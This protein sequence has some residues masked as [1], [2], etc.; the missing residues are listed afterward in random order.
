MI[1][2]HDV[3]RRALVVISCLQVTWPIVT[4]TAIEPL[5]HRFVALPVLQSIDSP[6]I[7]ARLI[8][9]RMA[10]AC[11]SAGYAP[12]YPTWP[13]RD[14]AVRSAVGMRPRMVLMRCQEH[15]RACLAKDR[16]IECLSLESAAIQAPEPADDARR[17]TVESLF[18][19]ERAAADPAAFGRDETAAA[20]QLLH[21]CEL[22]LGH[23]DCPMRST[24]RSSPTPIAETPSLH[25][26]LSFV[27]HDEG[28]RQQRWCFRWLA[29]GQRD[30]VP[31]AAKGGDDGL[32][33]RPGAQVPPSFR[34]CATAAPPRGAKTQ[35]TGRAVS[36]GRRQVRRANREPI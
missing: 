15:R 16:V 17:K 1:E 25:A 34:S 9:D 28:D 32:G 36:C 23:L 31:V 3:K 8:G 29:A 18:E 4:R 24:A 12:P 5:T 13:F 20:T 35:R 11:K 26:S 27:F 22:F 19:R 33:R 2:L 6:G 14:E 21:V 10:L 7:V 30:R